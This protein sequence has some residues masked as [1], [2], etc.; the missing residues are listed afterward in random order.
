VAKDLSVADEA[1]ALVDV[2]KLVRYQANLLTLI[3]NFVSFSHF[4]TRKDK[5][6]FQAGTLFID[7]RSCDLTIHVNDM[8][9]HSAMAGL[10]NTYLLYCE[11]SRKDQAK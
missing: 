6:I 8:A 3:N 10:S 2:D 5:A 11:C 1:N 9:K 4:Y 7:E